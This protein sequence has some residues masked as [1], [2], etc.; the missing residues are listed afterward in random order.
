MTL[1]LFLEGKQNDSNYGIRD[2]T[3]YTYKNSFST[4]FTQE[5]TDPNFS[6]ADGWLASGNK[7]G[8]IVSSCGDL[9]ILGGYDVFGQKTTASKTYSGLPKHTFVYITI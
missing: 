9:N 4:I 3:I 5:F 7:G 1:K 2:L 6:K 8:V